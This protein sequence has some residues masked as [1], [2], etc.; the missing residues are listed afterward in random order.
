MKGLYF[1]IVMLISVQAYAQNRVVY[2]H[3][4][5][6]DIFLVNDPRLLDMASS[7]AVMISK[8]AYIPAATQGF[9]DINARTLEEAA[10]VCPTEKFSQ[11][12]LAGR[13]SGFLVGPDTLVTAGHC[14][15]SRTMTPE[16]TC[17][18]YTWVFDFNM[19]SPNS[20]PEKNISINNIY[21]CKKIIAANL[22]GINDFSVIKLDRPVVGRRPLNFRGNGKLAD[23]TKLVVIGNPTGLPTKISGQGKILDNANPVAFITNLDTFQ[24]N[25]GSAVFD[26][27]TGMVEGILI[28]GKTDYVPSLYSNP[29]SC[30]V[31]NKC[32]GNGEGCRQP[33]QP[34][35]EV[36]FRIDQIAG[37][38]QQSFRM[39]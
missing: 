12:P 37:I 16:E 23:K 19:K 21:S 30:K 2:G 24:G 5:R 28:Q 8:K 14:Y 3:D 15:I 6:K 31:V 39:R 17:A 34:G 9:Y 27:T 4:N 18:A 36:V 33:S 7:T 13:C 26:A 11:Q 35:G 29:N 38:I 32:K 1:F 22:N 20:R 10:N 25:S